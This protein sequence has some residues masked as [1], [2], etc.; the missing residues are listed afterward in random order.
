MEINQ[1]L[2][3]TNHCLH[4]CNKSNIKEIVFSYLLDADAFVTNNVEEWERMFN[5]NEIKCL[6][7][8]PD[9]V[10]QS[11]KIVIDGSS[12]G[13]DFEKWELKW[14]KQSRAICIYNIDKI[15]PSILTKLVNVH[16]KMLLS[17]EK[18][19]MLSD[20]N[21]EKEIND[22]NPEIVETLVKKELKNIVLSLILAKPMSGNEL[23]KILYQ[24]FRVFISPGM[25]Y[26]AL[27]ELE[28]NG[29]L[30]FEYKLKNKVYSV[31]EKEQT[32]LLLKKHV[33]LNS[34]LSQFLLSE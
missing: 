5:E 34:L 8:K 1:I 16:D 2:C 24:K 33:R 19:R 25:L 11:E 10:K 3:F 6:I 31:Q 30:T 22:L 18:I 12:L 23:I 15:D 26:P 14:K 20:K 21:L 13:M 9:N 17:I 7:K 4:L 28:K 32:E 27:H 29:L